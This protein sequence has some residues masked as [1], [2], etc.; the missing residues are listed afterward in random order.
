M[1]TRR[2]LWNNR[3]IGDNG[4]ESK[5]MDEEVTQVE[6]G[7]RIESGGDL[8]EYMDVP[9]GQLTE[10]ETG[11]LNESSGK[12]TASADKE[13]KGNSIDMQAMLTCLPGVLGQSHCCRLDVP[14][15]V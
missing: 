4:E 12:K 3:V 2:S 6:G 14:C 11:R 5:M 15:A 13:G 7:V 9:C 10:G 1:I 8:E